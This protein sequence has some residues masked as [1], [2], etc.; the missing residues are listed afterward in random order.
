MK[1][2]FLPQAVVKKLS[3]N[4]LTSQQAKAMIL[5]GTNKRKVKHCEEDMRNKISIV[6]LK[7]FSLS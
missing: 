2:S 1:K 4:Y 6:V 7:G 5:I 3:D